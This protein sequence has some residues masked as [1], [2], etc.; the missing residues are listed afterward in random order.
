MI[1]ELLNLLVNT[2]DLYGNNALHYMASNSDLFINEKWKNIISNQSNKF[3]ISNQKTKY[4]AAKQKLCVDH[5]NN[6][7]KQN[8]Q[9][10]APLHY[11]VITKNYALV[12]TLLDH[13]ADINKTIQ[14]Y[15]MPSK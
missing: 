13:N 9:G 5:A 1:M 6:I 8:D 10:Y 11:A 14:H 3:V 2:Q 7:N 4:I 12:H 15:I